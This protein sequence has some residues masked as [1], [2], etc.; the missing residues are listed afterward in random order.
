MRFSTFGENV[1]GMLA[2]KGYSLEDLGGEV[3][4]IRLDGD[5]FD[6]ST[7]HRHKVGHCSV[8]NRKLYA[9]ALSRIYNRKITVEQLESRAIEELK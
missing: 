1:R 3:G 7:V 4:F 9:Q 5:G 6:R 2:A 8:K